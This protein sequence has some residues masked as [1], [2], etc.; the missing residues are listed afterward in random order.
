MR[1]NIPRRRV[2]Y[3]GE[4]CGRVSLSAFTV[5]SFVT[6][7]NYVR[8]RRLPAGLL[9]YLS[10]PSSSAAF[11]KRKRKLKGERE[12]AFSASSCLP[13]TKNSAEL[14]KGRLFSFVK[15]CGSTR[16]RSSFEARPRVGQ[17]VGPCRSEL[18]VFLR[19]TRCRRSARV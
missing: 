6:H 10:A 17:T 15:R 13:R 9:V 4:W 18:G 12:K 19:G 8:C 14:A 11:L 7:D 3:K 5:V 16:E 1:W 2:S